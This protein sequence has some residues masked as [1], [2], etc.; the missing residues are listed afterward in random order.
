MPRTNRR[1]LPPSLRSADPRSRG[2]DLAGAGGEPTSRIGKAGVVGAG[3]MGSGIA[4]VL[5]AAG[6]DV[7]MVDD[8]P[9]KA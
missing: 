7:M 5:A 2:A 8:A 6:I 1:A 4:E 9:G 3:V